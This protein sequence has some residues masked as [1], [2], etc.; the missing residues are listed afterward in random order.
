VSQREEN[1]HHLQVD[2]D[3]FYSKASD[4]ALLSLLG[5]L[6]KGSSAELG[7]T[8]VRDS[9]RNI[10]HYGQKKDET[11]TIPEPDKVKCLRRIKD[12]L[13]AVKEEYAEAEKVLLKISST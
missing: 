1:R 2:P 11:G 8:K 5:H 9:C 6:L 3:V 12:T 4:L 13:V 7:L 10:K